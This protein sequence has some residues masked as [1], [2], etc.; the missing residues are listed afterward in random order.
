MRRALGLAALLA[1]ACGGTS[2]EPTPPPAKTL[3]EATADAAWDTQVLREASVAANEVVRL[4]ADC[5]AARPIIGDARRKLDDAGTRVRT[6][7][8]RATL[9]ALHKQVDRV[10]DL[11]G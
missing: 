10:A 4:A 1:A 7:A 9:A 3:G 11:C 2:P 8:G 6:E 5:D